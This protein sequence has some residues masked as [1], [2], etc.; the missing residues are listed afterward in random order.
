MPPAT[1]AALAVGGIVVGA[2]TA[3]V[4]LVAGMVIVGI[5]AAAGGGAAA[6][7]QGGKSEKEKFLTLACDTYPDAQKWTDAIETQIREL[8]GS[9]YDFT[10][11][12]GPYSGVTNRSQPPEKKLEA[13]EQWL[14]WSKWKLST[15]LHGIR[16]Y[17]QDKLTSSMTATTITDSTTNINTSPSRLNKSYQ[18]E[19][20]ISYGSQL[21]R[22]NVG[23][24]AS[25]YDVFTVLMNMPQPCLSGII[26][27][28]KVIESMDNQTDIIYLELNPVYLTSTYTSKLFHLFKL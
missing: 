18:S 26:R 25:P 3:G 2:L 23:M 13:V 9:F 8:G 22:V 27:S 5:G 19:S 6:I 11:A 12:R 16:I 10:L 1:I 4:G 7:T 24:C 21:L 17:E 15:V 20:A 14:R 28:C